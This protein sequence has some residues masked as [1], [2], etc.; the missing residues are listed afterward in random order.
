MLEYFKTQLELATPLDSDE[1]SKM[2]SHRVE[3]G[4]N[5]A[6]ISDYYNSKIGK[7]IL[8]FIKTTL[9]GFEVCKCFD[10]EVDGTLK[11]A[12]FIEMNEGGGIPKFALAVE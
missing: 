9:N 4:Q 3:N 2:I 12:T 10:D 11:N 8:F 1:I 7:K 6:E 5:E